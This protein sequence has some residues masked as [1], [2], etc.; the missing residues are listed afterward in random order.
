V[1]TIVT[2]EFSHCV[3]VEDRPGAH[4]SAIRLEIDNNRG[5][6]LNTYLNRKEAL[7]LAKVLE[8]AAKGYGS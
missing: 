1:R 3:T 2:R 7:L 5:H 8:H 4:R 6:C